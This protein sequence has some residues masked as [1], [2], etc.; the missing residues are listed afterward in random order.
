[1]QTTGPDSPLRIFAVDD[2]QAQRHVLG[3]ILHGLAVI[4]FF[5]D[6]S[7]ALASLT[8]GRY[9]AAVIDVHLRRSR[10]DGFDLSRRIRAADPCLAIVIHTGDDSPAVLEDALDVRAIRRVLKASGKATLV[11][12]VQECARETREA[13]ARHREAE[14]GRESRRH[15]AEQARTTELSRTMADF[16][17]AMLR[18]LADDLTGLGVANA[19][20]R[21]LVARISDPGL[22]AT[23][24]RRLQ[25]ELQRTLE[26]GDG[27][28]ARL[29]GAY[30][31]MS[32]FS[33]GLFGQQTHAQTNVAVEAAGRI[34]ELDSRLAGLKI[35]WLPAEKEQVLP[36]PH[37]AVISG[38][39]S[40]GLFLLDNCEG[41]PGEFTLSVARVDRAA[42]LGLATQ[43]A[44]LLLLN[45]AFLDRAEFVHVRCACTP[46]GLVSA[47]VAPALAEPPANG[48]LYSLTLLAAMLSGVISIQR[49]RASGVV[50]M[51]FPAWR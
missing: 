15:L 29:N 3:A 37:L 41:M 16:H 24:R 20:S 47:S 31:R 44:P 23:A 48:R 8:A 9:D 19:A 21:S 51:L 22:P 35:K 33:D 11:Q 6:P 18:T 10:L 26:A 27:A 30:R 7:V 12:A 39:R 45:R 43:P 32:Q 25:E 1:M 46:S 2:D 40:A 5:S 14:L 49:T 28:L 50:E 17:H 4:D 34:L 42:A 13:R 38:V 36:A